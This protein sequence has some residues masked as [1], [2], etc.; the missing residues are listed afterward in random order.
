VQELLDIGAKAPKFT[1]GLEASDS[2]LDLPATN[3]QRSAS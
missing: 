1:A 3:E 2:V